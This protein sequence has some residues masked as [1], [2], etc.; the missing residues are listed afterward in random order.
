[1]PA[2]ATVLHRCLLVTRP[3]CENALRLRPLTSITSDA[4][5][6]VCTTRTCAT[7]FALTRIAAGMSAS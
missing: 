5:Q 1:M 6:L 3:A 2:T 4:M 7:R